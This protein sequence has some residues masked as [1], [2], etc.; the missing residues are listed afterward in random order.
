M[1]ILPAHNKLNKNII[2]NVQFVEKR[3]N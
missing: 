1:S 2:I 3:K